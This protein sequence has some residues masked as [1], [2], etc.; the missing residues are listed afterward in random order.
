MV[1]RLATRA[2]LVQQRTIGMID[3]GSPR[4]SFK[5]TNDKDV[6]A[7]TW[8]VT[9]IGTTPRVRL[10]DGGDVDPAS[11]FLFLACLPGRH[12]GSR[13]TPHSWQTPLL[14]WWSSFL[15]QQRTSYSWPIS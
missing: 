15:V 14:P 7:G 8:K 6:R 12:A 10:F 11:E 13:T 2:E 4:F 1:T 9:V 3:I 5:Y